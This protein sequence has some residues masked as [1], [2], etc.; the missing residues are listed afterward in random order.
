MLSCSA[1]ELAQALFAAVGDALIVYEPEADQLLAVKPVAVRLSP[2]A[3][4]Q[5]EPGVP[6]GRRGRRRRG[7]ESLRLLVACA[8]TGR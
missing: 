2:V 6:A 4:R 8:S 3:E 1:E 5:G 7:G